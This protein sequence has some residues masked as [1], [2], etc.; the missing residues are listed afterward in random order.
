MPESSFENLL[1]FSDYSADQII[2]DIIG[3]GRKKTSEM[4]W[5]LCSFIVQNHTGPG[6]N[7]LCSCL[8]NPDSI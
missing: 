3:T 7:E 1:C 4:P 8:I 2:C 6:G 5:F